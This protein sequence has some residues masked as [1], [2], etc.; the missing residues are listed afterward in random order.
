MYRTANNGYGTQWVAT[1]GKHPGARDAPNTKY[2]EVADYEKQKKTGLKQLKARIGREMA[3]VDQEV[4][5]PS[6]G[7]STISNFPT[8]AEEMKYPE[9]MTAGATNPMYLSANREYGRVQP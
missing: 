1:D 6:M 3:V 2:S 7:K 9:H 5:D 4:F 8:K